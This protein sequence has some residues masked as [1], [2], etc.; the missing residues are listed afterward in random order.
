MQRCGCTLAVLRWRSRRCGTGKEC[1]DLGLIEQ[2]YPDADQCEKIKRDF[3]SKYGNLPDVVICPCRAHQPGQPFAESCLDSIKGCTEAVPL[4]IAIECPKHW[5]ERMGVL[6]DYYNRESTSH[7]GPQIELES[8]AL[9]TGAL[10]GI[11]KYATRQQKETAKFYLEN[12]RG[13]CMEDVGAENY[14]LTSKEIVVACAKLKSALEIMAEHWESI[15]G[16]LADWDQEALRWFS[17]HQWENELETQA[18]WPSFGPLY[19]DEEKALALQPSTLALIYRGTGRHTKH[20]LFS[21]DTTGAIPHYQFKPEQTML[22]VPL[23]STRNR[24]A[25]PL[26]IIGLNHIPRLRN[27]SPEHSHL[28]QYNLVPTISSP[29]YKLQYYTSGRS[30]EWSPISKATTSEAQQQASIQKRKREDDDGWNDE[31]LEKK[32]NKINDL[33]PSINSQPADDLGTAFSQA[34]ETITTPLAYPQPTRRTIIQ[35]ELQTRF[36]Q[37]GESHWYELGQSGFGQLPHLDHGQ[38]HHTYC[39]QEGLGT[40]QREQSIQQVREEFAMVYGGSNTG[41]D[42][43]ALQHQQTVLQGQD[44]TQ[45]QWQQQQQL[46]EPRQSTG[47]QPGGYGTGY[48][49]SHGRWVIEDVVDRYDNRT[50]RR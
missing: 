46:E 45:Q 32:R 42:E 13:C 18:D 19:E 49:D 4:N 36:S 39:G 40:T 33:N 29:K 26:L 35:E 8:K 24:W 25:V 31:E 37:H 14:G 20:T 38:R 41:Y 34:R 7:L 30:Q 28:S 6:W 43:T 22:S 27:P 2:F 5:L 44:Q 21:A 48:F 9:I 12:V 10:S 23:G 17:A 47:E 15:H 11:W 50:Y 16:S 3:F 1:D